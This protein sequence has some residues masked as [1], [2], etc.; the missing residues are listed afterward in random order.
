M[1]EPLFQV[2]VACPHCESEYKTSRVRPSFKKAS[3]TDTDFYVRYKEINPDY[4]VVRV[5]PSCGFSCTENST[6]RL[7][8]VQKQAF[9]GKVGGQWTAKDYGG[10]RSWDN[11]LYTYKL[12]LL[13]AQTV[14]EKN[15]ITAGLLHHIAW[16]YRDRGETEQ[17]QRFLSYALDEY[18]RVFETEG[19][20]LNNA[21]L[22][23]LI[24]ELNRRLRNY[25]QAVR[26]FARV[27]NDR[28]IMDAAMIRACREQW[29][30]TREDMKAEQF[31]LDE[32]ARLLK[33]M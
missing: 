27:I 8:S 28:R 24:G 10:E 15:R 25:N 2:N 11:A 33:E 26:W 4:Y 18:T 14:K 13:C 6:E 17:E 16:L 23:Y 1:V 9:A 12:A 3:G 21:R 19:N 30:V 5:C 31:E 22:M 32:E 7:N 29:A 20:E